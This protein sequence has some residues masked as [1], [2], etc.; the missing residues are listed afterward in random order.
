MNG[1]VRTGTTGS[2][3]DSKKKKT[4][5]PPLNFFA[6]STLDSAEITGALTLWEKKKENI[7]IFIGGGSAHIS[8]CCHFSYI[9]PF[10][11]SV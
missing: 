4:E 9:C 6:L 3:E 8:V 1:M 11:A 5:K 10:K 2:V 7:F